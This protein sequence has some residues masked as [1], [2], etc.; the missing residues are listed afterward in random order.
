MTPKERKELKDLDKKIGKFADMDS[1]VLN[2][3]WEINNK[4]EK[5]T[6]RKVNDFKTKLKQICADAGLIHLAEKRWAGQEHDPAIHDDSNNRIDLL[7]QVIVAEYLDCF[8][9]Q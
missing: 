5:G 8:R 3:F 4:M 2:S 6:L 1:E 9:K 7:I